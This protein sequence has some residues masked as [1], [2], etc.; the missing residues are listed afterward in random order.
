MKYFYT[1]NYY[2]SS[3]VHLW[4]DSSSSIIEKE[5]V[6]FE[7]GFMYCQAPAE[8]QSTTDYSSCFR[9]FIPDLNALSWPVFMCG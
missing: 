5:F 3:E 7:T 6:L 1:N 4:T 9:H 8:G 2:L